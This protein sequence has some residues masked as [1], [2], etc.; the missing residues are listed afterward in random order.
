MEWDGIERTR[1]ASATGLV[2]LEGAEQSKNEPNDF[3]CGTLTLSENFQFDVRVRRYDARN[4][5]LTS[6]CLPSNR[7]YTERGIGIIK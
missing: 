2:F 5:R 3:S 4:N 7:K 1:S 6:R